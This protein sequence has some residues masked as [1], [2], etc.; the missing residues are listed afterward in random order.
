MRHSTDISWYI[1]IY[2]YDYLKQYTYRPLKE[3]TH[4]PQS[5]KNSTHTHTQTHREKDGFLLPLRCF[6]HRFLCSVHVTDEVHILTPPPPPPTHTQS[7]PPLP[8]PC[9]H[10]HTPYAPSRREMFTIDS[11]LVYAATKNTPFFFHFSIPSI[12]SQ[13][14]PP[15][16]PPPKKR[17]KKKGNPLYILCL[18]C[19]LPVTKDGSG[20]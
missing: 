10:T 6:T 13:P 2:S 16:P 19:L 5:L 3:K 11:L 14:L 17:K 18:D 1:Y 7:A 20:S 4:V 8:P 12:L 9:T 15:P